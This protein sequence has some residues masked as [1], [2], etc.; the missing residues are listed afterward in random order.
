LSRRELLLGIFQ[1]LGSLP[2]EAVGLAQFPG[3][4][5]EGI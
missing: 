2:E 1:A 4:A 5:L 3:R